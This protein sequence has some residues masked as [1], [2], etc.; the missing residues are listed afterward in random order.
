MIAGGQS[1]VPLMNLRL[2]RPATLVDVNGLA[3]LDEVTDDNGS[4][5]V[6]ALCRHR[7]LELDPVV[8]AHVPLLAGGGARHI[9]RPAIRN[10]GTIGGS[11]AHGDPAGELGAVLVAL[12]GSVRVRSVAGSARSARATCSRA[13]SRP[14]SVTTKSSSTSVSRCV[15]QREGSAFVEFAP[16]HGDFAV[17]GIAARVV[18]DA[19]GRCSA[20]RMAACGV[21]AVPADLSAALD[22]VVGSHRARRCHAHGGGGA[23]PVALRSDVRPPGGRGGP[24]RAG[25][26]P[27][28]RRAEASPGPRG[29]RAG[30]CR[31]SSSK[32]TGRSARWSSQPR[33][34][35][36]DVLRD[37]TSDSRARTPG[38]S[39]GA[40][41]ACTVLR[42]RRARALVPDVRR[43]GRGRAVT[44]RR[45]P[46]AR[47]RRCTR[48]RRRS[49]SAT[50][51]QCGFCT[52]A[53]ILAAVELL[54][55][56]GAPSREAIEEALSGQLCRCTGYEPIIEAVVLAASRARGEEAIA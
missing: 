30:R 56:D 55:R 27:R 1:L 7:R 16:R 32:S 47:R 21:A 33:E 17:V 29:R 25:P 6:G 12:E 38:A 41:G 54:S 48:S 31:R 28:G 15:G 13:S 24:A 50:A 4:L 37:R 8:A 19:H 53:M 36:L 3:E 14:P 20:A 39:T 10:R 2:A 52:P 42:R 51:L 44:D 23:R 49:S 45:G 22:G 46:R 11:L 5:V 9:G 40:C 18:L 43:A 34:L 35:L 26:A